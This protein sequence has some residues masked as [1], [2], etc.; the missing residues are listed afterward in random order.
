MGVESAGITKSDVVFDLYCGIGTITI[1]MS[2]Y[3]KKVYGIEIVEEA[4][5][6]AK[7][8]AQINDVQNII[9]NTNYLKVIMKSNIKKSIRAKI[10]SFLKNFIHGFNPKNTFI[11]NLRYLICYEKDLRYLLVKYEYFPNRA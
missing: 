8:N 7:D 1:F 2:K 10:W 6:M 5:E 4:I 3:A 9:L 11:I